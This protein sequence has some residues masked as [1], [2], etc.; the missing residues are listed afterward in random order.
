VQ[1]HQRAL[2]AAAARN[3]EARARVA[4]LKAAVLAAAAAR[5]AAALIDAGGAWPARQGAPAGGAAAGVGWSFVEAMLAR[6][7]Q[8]LA[9]PGGPTDAGA[10]RQAPQL[11]APT[12]L[13][14]A[15]QR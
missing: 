5:E 8:A 2:S 14:A 13:L 11:A 6:A 10:R 3:A 4:L 15:L 12:G 7:Q 1:G 9:S